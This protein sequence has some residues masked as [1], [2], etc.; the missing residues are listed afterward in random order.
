M[1]IYSDINIFF[2]KIININN[3]DIIYTTESKI[4]VTNKYY[5]FIYNKNN[6]KINSFINYIID[7]LDDNNKIHD[8]DIK[9]LCCT[10]SFDIDQIYVWDIAKTNIKEISSQVNNL[11]EC[12]SE[13]F[14][15][16]DGVI[17]PAEIILIVDIESLF[18]Y[19]QLFVNIE[20]NNEDKVEETHIMD[21]IFFLFKNKI[22][23]IVIL[24]KYKQLHEKSLLYYNFI[25]CLINEP[26]V[27]LANIQ[28]K[29]LIT[30]NEEILNI[31]SNKI[32]I[33]KKCDSIYWNLLDVNN[34]YN[35]YIDNGDVNLQELNKLLSEENLIFAK[36]NGIN[37]VI[38]NV[39]IHEIINTNL[40]SFK[41][42]NN[43]FIYALNPL[44]QNNIFYV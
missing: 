1:N 12:A 24:D 7:E 16:D 15:T 41:N 32:I 21:Y 40:F 37:S 20:K 36:I 11:I 34:K 8:D 23:N 25:N 22:N 30:I 5:I 27:P 31:N 26:K 13:C 2:E 17:H 42:N 4:P 10:Q 14:E 29:N 44:H 43:S 35:I 19:I 38:S 39:L 33:Y 3:N 6:K 18:N 9:Q 28:D